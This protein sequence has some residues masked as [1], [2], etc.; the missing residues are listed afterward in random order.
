M[1]A[2]LHSLIAA[3]VTRARFS[4]RVQQVT[5]QGNI[6]LFQV[7]GPVGETNHCWVKEKE[8]C[9][10]K[11]RPGSFVEFTA[12]IESYWKGAGEEDICLTRVK[13]VE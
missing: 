3:G 8:W 12:S 11:P 13:V 7:C 9:G 2:D 1:R 5:P 4:A 10:T 6:S